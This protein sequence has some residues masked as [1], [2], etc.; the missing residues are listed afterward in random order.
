MECRGGPLAGI[1]VLEIESIGPG[2]FTAMLLADLGANVLRVSRPAMTPRRVNPVLERGR[3]GSVTVDLKT[4][5]GREQVLA[6]VEQADVLIEGFRPGVMERLGLGPEACLARNPRLVFGRVTGWGNTG[7]LAQ[8]AGHDINYISISGALHAMGTAESGPMPPL[9][10]VGDY[11]GG[12]LL[13]AFGIV[14]ALLETSR[15]ER[16]QVVDAAMIDGAAVLMAPLFGVKAVGGWSA[17]RAGNML[18][19]SS[20]YYTVYPC[21]DGWVSVGPLETE[22]RRTLLE[23]LGLG[24]EVETLLHAPATDSAARTR[25]AA[26]FAART[27]AEW[28]AVFEGTDACVASILSMD[29]AVAHPQIRDRDTLRVVAGAVH[30]VPAP[31]FS[32]TPNPDP[33]PASETRRELLAAWGA[34]A[35]GNKV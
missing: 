3:T 16:G 12:G 10:L 19:G 34:A 5:S 6:L 17:D 20:W 27:R 1:R 7:P 28:T 14:S 25:L 30:P 31:R 24:D 23:K 32:R 8:R 13:L 15:S 9:N 26:I 22:F 29:E 2:P 35:A 11:G 33:R 4:E 21:A 18:D